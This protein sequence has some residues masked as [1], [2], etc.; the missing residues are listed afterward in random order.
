[1]LG[2]YVE[3][4]NTQVPLEFLQ[5]GRLSELPANNNQ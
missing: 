4:P 1:M 2:N 3:V 5:T